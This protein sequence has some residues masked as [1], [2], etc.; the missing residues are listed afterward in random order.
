MANYDLAFTGAQIDSAIGKVQN[1][2]TSV[3]DSPNMIESSAVF[4]AINGLTTTNFTS[5]TLVTSSETFPDNDTTIPTCAAVKAFVDGTTAVS[6]LSR[7]SEYI[8]QSETYTNVP[9]VSVNGSDI[10]ADGD[11]TYTIKAGVYA[12]EGSAELRVTSS[13]GNAQLR[14]AAG[15]G[16]FALDT[17]LSRSGTSF[18]TVPT[19]G[20]QLLYF[21]S[22]TS[23]TLQFR[24]DPANGT[25]S[26]R[27]QNISMNFLRIK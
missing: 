11:G 9:S 6:T 14:I 21:S 10:T 27:V 17:T 13:S 24:D 19:T 1:A 2:E 15:S 16:A 22:D 12:F 25:Y 23:L 8:L 7:A 3:A 26:V 20:S 4:T 18:S 5:G